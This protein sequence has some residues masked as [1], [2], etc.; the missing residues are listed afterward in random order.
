M[1]VLKRI[2]QD[3][4]QPDTEMTGQIEVAEVAATVEVEAEEIEA[5]EIEEAEEEEEKTVEVEEVIEEEEE[6]EA[7]EEAAEV[8]EETEAAKATMKS[9][10]SKEEEE[11]EERVQEMTNLPIRMVNKQSTSQRIKEKS[12]TLEVQESQESQESQEKTDQRKNKRK[13]RRRL[14]KLSLDNRLRISCKL[15]S[16]RKRKKPELL[17][18]LKVLSSW[19]LMVVQRTRRHKRLFKQALV[20]L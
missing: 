5:E 17:R 12:H 16:P 14:R 3:Q 15:E 9:S 20:P 2:N 10:P 8:E 4:K 19:L 18:E 13:P 11:A 6:K 1:R 7:V